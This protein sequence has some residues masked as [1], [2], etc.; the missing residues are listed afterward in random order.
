MLPKMGSEGAGKVMCA[1]S[2]GFSETG[3]G[4]SVV[5]ARTGNRGPPCTKAVR[6]NAEPSPEAGE[7]VVSRGRR[8]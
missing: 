5:G 3:R 7:V 6:R 1:A 4:G 2:K 8:G